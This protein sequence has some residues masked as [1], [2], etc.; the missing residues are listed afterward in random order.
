MH[1][2]EL[3]L[4]ARLAAVYTVLNAF[5][6]IS[7]VELV[8]LIGVSQ[9]AA[10]RTGHAIRDMMRADCG[11]THCS[12]GFSKS[13]S[14][15]VPGSRTGWRRCR[16]C[17]LIVPPPSDRGPGGPRSKF[18]RRARNVGARWCEC[19][20]TCGCPPVPRALF[21]RRAGRRIRRHGRSIVTLSI[22]SAAV[23]PD[24]HRRIRQGLR[25]PRAGELAALVR[26]E[27]GRPEPKSI[28]RCLDTKLGVHGVRDAPCQH[29]ACRP[30][31]D[32][33][34]RI[35]MQAISAHQTWFGRSIGR[36]R[37]RDGYLR[38]SG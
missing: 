18:V 19:R 26:V 6:G 5:N 21:R 29:P 16:A 15:V 23:H 11:K 20:S 30:A 3:D 17:R 10:W 36:P 38:C 37:S 28:V 24:L 25:E 1:G 14:E 2:T 32:R 7:S 8:R 13:M 9:T 31:H 35:G 4:R 34:R 12:P 33:D 22:R 27:S